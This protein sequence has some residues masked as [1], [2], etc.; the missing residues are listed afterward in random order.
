MQLWKYFRVFEISLNLGA[1]KNYYRKIFGALSTEI[2]V[3]SL[4]SMERYEH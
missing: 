3:S 1:I 4:C 2:I